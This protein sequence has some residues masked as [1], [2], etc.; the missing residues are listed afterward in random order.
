[1]EREKLC[2]CR[3]RAE[4]VREGVFC[5]CVCVCKALGCGRVWHQDAKCL[6]AAFLIM[7]C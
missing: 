5:V 6:E 4:R 2:C 7:I 3:G 1:M